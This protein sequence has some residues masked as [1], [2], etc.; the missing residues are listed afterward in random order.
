MYK[1]LCIIIIRSLWIHV[2]NAEAT[3]F[4]LTFLF[5]DTQSTTTMQQIVRRQSEA[6]SSLSFHFFVF[7]VEKK[8]TTICSFVS[9]SSGMHSD[10][11]SVVSTHICNMYKTIQSDYVSA[12][13]AHTQSRRR[14]PL[15][16]KTDALRHRQT[17][18]FPSICLIRHL[19]D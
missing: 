14:F 11:V 8:T 3:R 5:N 16:P 4:R 10:F 18:I 9:L 13:P 15:W 2:M 12:T 19:S 7:C 17:R 6:N 1:F